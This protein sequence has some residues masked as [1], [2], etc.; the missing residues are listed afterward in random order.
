MSPQKLLVATTSK[1]KLK[2][3]QELLADLPFDLLAL[4]DLPSHQ[5][6]V[7]DGKSFLENATKKALGY[8]RQ[9]GFLTLGEDSGLCCDALEGAPGIYSARFA[10]PQATDDANNQKLLK[11]F[12]TIPDN[13]RGAHYESAVVIATPEKIVGQSEGSVHGFIHKKLEGNQGFGYDPLFYYPPFQMTFGC[14]SP[15]KKHSVSHRFNA[16]QKAKKLLMNYLQTES[17]RAAS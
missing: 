10:G 11:L 17:S 13:C 3:L 12:E 8:A 16:L 2:E 4:S 6:V 15:E 1:K 14:I 5:E 7:E 9:S